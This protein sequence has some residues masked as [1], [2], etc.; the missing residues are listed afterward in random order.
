M[1]LERLDIQFLRNI[2]SARLSFSPGIN[3]ISGLNASGKTS[4]LEAISLVIQ[5]KSFRT[6]RL[7]LLVQHGQTEMVVS[8]HYRQ[9]NQRFQVGIARQ[10][11]KTRVK[12][13]GEV[14]T[15]TTELVG[16][17][18]LFIL[19]P[20]SHE[21]LDSGPK[22]RRHYLDWGVF[23][24]E[25]HYLN[26]WQRYHRILRQRNTSLRQQASLST[27]R[28]WDSPLVE[29]A[30]E[31]DQ[32]RTGYIEQLTP[33]IAQF[34]EEI[35][36]LTPNVIYQPG[37]KTDLPLAEQLQAAIGKDQQRGFTSLGPHRADLKIHYQG[38]PVHAVLSRGQQKLL[39][40][41]MT[42]A[43]LSVLNQQ[44]LILVDDLPAELDT[45]KRATLLESLRGTGAQ[46]VVTATDA[47]LIDVAGWE[48]KKMF[49]VEH[50]RIQESG[51]MA[52][53]P[54]EH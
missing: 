51:I 53:S 35:L 26:H 9:G 39:I 7:N 36:G 42:L 41:A 45:V 22:M 20:E 25:H 10:E 33:K 44:C 2:E 23:H 11:G 1:A 17:L 14:V 37:W 13:N 28:A 8:G 16:Q 30:T 5:G 21:L 15:R 24:V 46:V 3:V 6:P 52:R 47:G 43:Q 18:P 31:I 29:S 48:E 50:G 27:V 19:T 34:S 12:R 32:L 4:I 40:C 49:H 38:Q 54:Q